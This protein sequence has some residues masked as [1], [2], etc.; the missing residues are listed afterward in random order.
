MGCEAIVFERTG[1]PEVLEGR[2]VPLPPPGPGEV[3]VA[4]AAIGVNYI[5]VYHRSGLYPVALPATPGLEA[6]GV[7]TA[8]GAGVVGARPGDRVAYVVATPGSYATARNVAAERLVALPPGVDELTAAATLLKGLTAWYLLHRTYPV[9]PRDTILVHA[10][11]GG[12]GLLLCQW[13]RALGATVIGTAGTEEKAALARAHGCHHTIRY[14]EEDV[15]ARVREL[16]GGEGVPVVY[17][18]VGA[19]TFAASL[20]SLA[21]LG[22]LVSVGNASG[23][24]PPISPLTLGQKGS[25]TLT[26]PSLFHHIARGADLRAGAAALFDAFERGAV[27]A[28]SVTTRPLADAAEVHRELE[29]RRTTG[30]T[31]LVA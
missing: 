12:L 29:A 17:D 26:R 30:S 22:V 21:P 10:A 24:P 16:T 27:E 6:A 31:V 2:D 9:R 7:V 11:A 8:V 3:Q 28:R 5:D 1:G 14:T 13:A 18:A 25:L 23:P 15:A 20:D 19:A 4:H